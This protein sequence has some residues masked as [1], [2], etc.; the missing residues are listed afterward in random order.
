MTN[1]VD[2]PG[3][4][5]LHLKG[6]T[7]VIFSIYGTS[8][9]T[10]KEKKAEAKK[11]LTDPTIVEAKKIACTDSTV[12]KVTKQLYNLPCSFFLTAVRIGSFVEIKMPGLMA[13]LKRVY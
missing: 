13:T 2:K 3:M 6:T 4:A 8:T 7:S 10:A 9:R 11:I 5:A 1:E 12:K